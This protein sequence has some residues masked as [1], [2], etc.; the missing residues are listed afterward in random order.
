M[1]IQTVAVYSDADAGAPHVQAADTSVRIGPAPVADSYL[2]A[3]AILTAARTSGAEAIHP[4][5]GFLSENAGFAEAVEAEK[6]TVMMGTPTFLRPYF[7][8][9]QPDQL[10]S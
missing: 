2:N 1:D 7:K 8:R 4:G 5:Y 3:D 10:K 9:A 6:V